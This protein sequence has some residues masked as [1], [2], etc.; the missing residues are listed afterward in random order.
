MALILSSSF[1]ISLLLANYLYFFLWML[2]RLRLSP[3]IL[4]VADW[5]RFYFIYIFD[6]V[7]NI[8]CIISR[9]IH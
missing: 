1:E 6:V 7:S 2:G 8:L 5:E 4:G 3:L 9:Y